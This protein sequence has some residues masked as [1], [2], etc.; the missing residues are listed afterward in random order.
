[1]L[2]ERENGL[3]G[4]ACFSLPTPAC[5]RMFS[6]LLTPAQKREGTG[7]Q[8]KAPAP[9]ACMFFGSAVGQTLS[10]VNSAVLRG[11]VA[12]LLICALPIAASA[13]TRPRYG[14]TLRVEIHASIETRS[15]E[16]RVGEGGSSR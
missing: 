6:Q 14:G 4:G 3:V 10:S 11:V 12:L 8:A 9:L 15:E 1:M 7:W 5:G 16:R 2:K 13:A